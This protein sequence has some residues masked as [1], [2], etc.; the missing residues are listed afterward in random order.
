[1]D[2]IASTLGGIPN[3]IPVRLAANFDTW[4]PLAAF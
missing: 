2:E 4:E 1:M 3:G